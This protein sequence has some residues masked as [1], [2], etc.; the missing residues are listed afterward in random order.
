MSPSGFET[1]SFNGEIV[2]DL[3][4]WNRKRQNGKVGDSSTG[5]KLPNGAI[6]SPGASWVSFERL[7]KLTSAEREKFPNVCPEF[8]IEILSG[9]AVLPGFAL[10]LRS[11]Q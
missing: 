1:G 5:Y 10:Q 7:E 11:L 6:R 3:N 2:T 8:V 9:E 4:I